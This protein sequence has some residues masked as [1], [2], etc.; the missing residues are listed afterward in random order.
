[1]N[2]GEV[3]DLIRSVCM[4]WS[5]VAVSL[6]HTR[7]QWSFC[8]F[9]FTR[10]DHQ[11]FFRAEMLIRMS[12]TCDPWPSARKH[13]SMTSKQGNT[14]TLY[15]QAFFTSI[16]KAIW[17]GEGRV[18]A[19]RRRYNEWKQKQRKKKT[20]RWNFTGCQGRREN[21]CEIPAQVQVPV[22]FL[23]PFSSSRTW[24]MLHACKLQAT[25]S[26]GPTDT[27]SFTCRLYE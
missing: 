26:T 18:G 17:T 20:F 14:R 23:W 21:A 7:K 4:N 11:P 8:Q 25:G 19:R 2:F 27:Y 1:M 3:N 16:L 9:Y 13:W 10:E 24:W 22:L 15:L 12:G 5:Q 6:G